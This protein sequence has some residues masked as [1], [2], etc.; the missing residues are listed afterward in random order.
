M[1]KYL[2]K[3]CSVR[4]KYICKCY[5]VSTIGNENKQMWFASNKEVGRMV[6]IEIL[7][8]IIKLLFAGLVS[9]TIIAFALII[10]LVVIISKQI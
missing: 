6:E 10:A 5:I 8:I 1:L 4:L 3:I 9:V 7:H 2:K